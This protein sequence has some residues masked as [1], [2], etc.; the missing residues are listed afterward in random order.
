MLASD[1]TANSVR[2]PSTT[3]TMRVWTLATAAEPTMLSA[4]MTAMI[5]TAK[6]LSHAWLPSVNA[7]LA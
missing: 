4:V 6:T 1:V 7:P 3:Y 5:A 2:I